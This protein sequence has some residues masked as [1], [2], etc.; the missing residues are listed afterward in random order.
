MRIESVAYSIDWRK[1]HK[2]YSV[3]V[4]CINHRRAKAAFN[5]VADRLGMQFVYK[6]VVVDG[7]KGLRVWRV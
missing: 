7:V 6:V 5:D 4:P 3:F 2:G 1:M